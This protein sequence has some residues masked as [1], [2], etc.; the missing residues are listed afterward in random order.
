[1]PTQSQRQSLVT[2]DGIDGYWAQRTGGEGETAI[3]RVYNGG[4]KM[5]EL[6]SGPTTYTD[7]V[8]TRPYDRVRDGQYKAF[9]LAG[10]GS[11]MTTIAEV[12]T[13][14][15]LIPQATGVSWLG[16]LTHVKFPETNSGSGAA[17]E[18]ALTFAVANAS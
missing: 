18:I 8:V 16:K 4:D 13:D 6:L 14:S 5:A 2:V 11:W 17:A 1:M 10:Q 15:N 3:T 12:D 9:L 7:L